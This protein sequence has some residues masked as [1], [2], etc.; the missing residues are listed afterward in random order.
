VGDSYTAGLGVGKRTDYGCSRYDGGYP[1]IIGLDDRFG[2]NPNRTFQSLACSGLKS[3]DILK[4]QVPYLED[5]I[6][7][8][9]V[10]AGGNDVAL[11]GVLDACIFQFKRGSSEMC[12]KALNTSQA[13]ID[14]DLS[15]NMD[16]LLEGLVAKLSPQGKIYMPG[17]A[18]FFG[19]S[20]FCDNVTWS[21]WPRLPDKDKQRLTSSRRARMNSM[22]SQT[23]AK[24]LNAT[25]S[26]GS[27][28]VFVDFDWAFAQVN[29]RFCEED[30]EE[31]APNRASLLFYEWDTLD[32]GDDPRLV[33]RPGDPVPPDTFEGS[34]GSWILETLDAH[35]DWI[36]FGPEGSPPFHIT[37][38][39]FRDAEMK[40]SDFEA[41][42]GFDDLVFWFL[43]DSW[44]RVFHPRAIG[45]LIIADMILHEMATARG[46][47]LGV[48]VPKYVPRRVGFP[49]EKLKN[50]DVV[51]NRAVCRLLK[52]LEQ[53]ATNQLCR[54]ASVY[55]QAEPNLN[56]FFPPNI[57]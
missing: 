27:Q 35:P 50:S 3:T 18:Q 43:P 31:P 16:L 53:M 45:H 1:N 51:T 20:Q 55:S 2:F 28:V 11:G 21:V 10:S 46:K 15:S 25:K 38:Q 30:V 13:L 7:V 19:L 6:D 22:V 54:R 33:T 4:K 42:M 36:D 23:N 56:P 48:E 8:I 49:P 14:A 47:V 44:K 37:R 5:D 17:Y 52:T 39:A 12:E 26:F 24:I 40:A 32:D 34:I 29:G 9:T 57:V 41:Q